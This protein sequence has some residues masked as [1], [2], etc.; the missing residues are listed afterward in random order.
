[1]LNFVDNPGPA[2]VSPLLIAHGLFGS[3]RNWSVI[4]KRLSDKR[5]VIVVDHRNHGSSPWFESHSYHDLAQDLGEVIAH[6]GAPCDVVGHSMGGKAAMALALLTPEL[7][8]RLCIADIAPVAYGHDQ[9]Q[10]IKAM[11]M[12]D[13]TTIKNRSDVRVQLG[14]KVGDI[15][16]RNFLVQ[17]VDVEHRRWRLNLNVLEDEMPKILGFPYIDGVF[18][19]KTLFLLG[20][21]SS[22]VL[23][24]MRGGIKARFPAAVFA[25]IPN[26]GHWIHSERPRAFEDALRVFFTNHH[27]HYRSAKRI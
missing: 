14:E 9:S 6:V 26:A 25:K 20:G 27:E 10:F 4:A 17:S 8:A 12:V 15:G 22:Y 7:V 24:E 3:A 1:M 2:D 16:L 11:K 13:F 21:N 18:H 19:G 23:P 5:R